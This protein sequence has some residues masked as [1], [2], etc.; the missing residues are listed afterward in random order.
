MKKIIVLIASGFGLGLS[1]WASGTVGSLPGL[2]IVLLVAPL[3]LPW[4]TLLAVGLALAAIPVC[5]VAENYYGKKDDHRIVADE[6]MTFPIC[7][8]GLPWLAHPWLLGVAFVTNRILDI[9]KPPPARQAQALPGGFGIVLD[10]V[11]SSLY[12][13]ALNHVIWLVAKLMF[14]YS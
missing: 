9:V 8:L 2:V 1:P 6:Y 14:R 10:D 3:S 11:A 7:V 4:Q 12:A 5:S 13:L